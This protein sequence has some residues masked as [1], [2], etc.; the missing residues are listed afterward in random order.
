MNNLNSVLIEGILTQNPEMS[1]TSKGQPICQFSLSC[2]RFYKQDDE[3]QKEESI[4]DIT[5][6][7]KMAEVCN[8]NLKK[9]RGVRVVGRLK[10][11]RITDDNGGSKS[12]VYIIAEHVEFKPVIK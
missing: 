8:E 12:K 4:F 2:N 7:N 6:L 1:N 9:D 10:E 3:Y 5:V 11:D